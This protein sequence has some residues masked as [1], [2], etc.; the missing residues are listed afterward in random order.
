MEQIQVASTVRVYG[1]NRNQ[2]QTPP[3]FYSTVNGFWRSWY[4][5]EEQWKSFAAD[6]FYLRTHLVPMEVDDLIPELY[7]A[8]R[9]H[10]LQ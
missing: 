7:T 9:N 4:Q 6:E 1:D 10:Y 2:H 8:M 5:D 3:S